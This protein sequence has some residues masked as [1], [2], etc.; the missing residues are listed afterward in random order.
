MGTGYNS[1]S[2][3]HQQVGVFQWTFSAMMSKHKNG[4]FSVG[5]FVQKIFKKETDSLS[6]R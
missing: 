4:G 1:T 2:R 3:Q 5:T 6:L